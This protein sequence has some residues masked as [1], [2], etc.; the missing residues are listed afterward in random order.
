VK[1]QEIFTKKKSFFSSFCPF[2]SRAR[3]KAHKFCEPDPEKRKTKEKFTFFVTFSRRG[4][5]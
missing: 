4:E 1:N 3:R 5:G 2:F